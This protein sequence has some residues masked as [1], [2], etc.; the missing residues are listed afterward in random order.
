[1]E[2]VRYIQRGE[3][4]S[5]E[6][7]NRPVKDLEQLVSQL[8]RKV[9]ILTDGANNILLNQPLDESVHV[10]SPVYFDKLTGRY[11]RARLASRIDGDQIVCDDS[12]YVLGVVIRKSSVQTGDICLNGVVTIDLEEGGNQDAR[13]DYTE[14][15]LKYLSVIEG[16]LT[17]NPPPLAIPV[18]FVL[19][20]HADGKATICICVNFDRVL[21]GHRHIRY[22][23]KARPSGTWTT[24]SAQIG[25]PQASM[26]GWLPADLSTVSSAPV[27]ARFFYNFSGTPLSEAFPLTAPE[28]FKVHWTQPTSAEDPVPVLAEVPE[29][30]IRITDDGIWWMSSEYVPWF[31]N[32]NWNA[33]QCAVNPEPHV[34][35]EMV[36][37]YTKVTYGTTEA[38]VT[39]LTSS[40][41][42][43]IEVLGRHTGTPATRGDLILDFD[44]QNKVASDVMSGSRSLK[45]VGPG[46]FNQT[47]LPAPGDVFD[48]DDP[49]YIQNGMF[50]GPTVESVEVDSISCEVISRDNVFTE[51]GA[52]S[53]QILLRLRDSWSFLPLPVQMIRLD[54]MR[55]AN[56]GGMG[57][58]AFLPDTV[59]GFSGNIYLPWFRGQTSNMRIRFTLAAGSA[60]NVN[61]GLF[62]GRYAIIPATECNEANH[63]P[64]MLPTVCEP[65]GNQDDLGLDFNVSIPSPQ[66]YFCVNTKAIEVTPGA[67]IWFSLHKTAGGPSPLS[68]IRMEAYLDTDEG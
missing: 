62:N 19:G 7:V 17:G 66:M 37:Y 10:G 52:P 51:R 11:S 8:L 67:M 22:P 68:V 57:A 28:C 26:E 15:G 31:A 42:S 18:A 36:A 14:L 13:Q 32:A 48:K 54:Q 25:M 53:G 43:G 46:Y 33:G 47:N 44:L 34:M 65:G 40:N 64:A 4:V 35:L 9:N 2:V 41:T 23:L 29:K 58:I 21:S 49:R 30:L 5:P 16:R 60:G 38:V 12:A 39:S 59:S 61:S 6:V 1:M 45:Y 56:I 50:F 20:V 55:D 24:G 27:G 63:F 3:P